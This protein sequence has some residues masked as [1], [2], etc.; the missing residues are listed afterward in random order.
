MTH[1]AAPAMG[2][3]NPGAHSAVP[4][5][6]PAPAAPVPESGRPLRRIAVIG[7]GPA[8]VYAADILLRAERPF[9]VGI[10]VF[11]RVPAPYGLVRYGVAPDHPRIKQIIDALR[12]TLDRS[13]VRLFANVDFGRDLTLADLRRC[14]DA[15]I[16]ATGA[17]DDAPLSIPGAD[18]P[19]SFG[20][21]R[22]VGWY[23]AHPDFPRTWPLDQS[24]VAVIGNGNV[25]LDVTRILAKPVDALTVT[26]IPAGVE[27]GLR[28]SQVTDVHVFGRRGP[29]AVKFSPLETRELGQVPD[30]DIL[31][32]E[33][34]FAPE[35]FSDAAFAA[36]NQKKVLRRIFDEW[37]RRPQTG[38]A[39][40]I[41][42]H[43]RWRPVAVLGTDRV[44]GLRMERTRTEPDGTLVGTAE[45]RDFPV[46]QV[47]H[48]IGYQGSP[49][50][51][52]PY[53]A[54]R[55]VIANVEGRVVADAAA[56]D[57][58]AADASAA[59][60]IPGEYTTGWIKRGPVGLIG[61]TKSDARETVTH[62]I[63]DLAAGRGWRPES[64]D[65]EAVV[66][67]LRERGVQFL[68]L[69][70][71]HRLDAYEHQLG[72]DAGRE[73]VKVVSREDMVRHSRGE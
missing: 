7:A 1:N 30:V 13:G 43:F 45:L 5:A 56:V 6:H 59:A 9:D 63:E 28:A 36:T 51:E 50:P 33:D 49:L 22:F 66:R 3:P 17:V 27:D 12:D 64:R 16:F 19:G 46:G 23:D 24:Q 52:V 15:V 41:H 32:D 8:G 39:R 70:A 40:R 72:A 55:G 34:D 38:A 57:V 61:S 54:A 31:L 21:A 14:Y 18:L 25:A 58:S 35:P 71:W 4:G 42:F 65:A 48:A 69:P 47:Y 53:D 29:G 10:D 26:E 37:R 2:D 68:D 11:E 60:A 73:R 44:T 67:L 62:L 20:A